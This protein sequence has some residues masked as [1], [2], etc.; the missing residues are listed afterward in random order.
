MSSNKYTGREEETKT[1]AP[2]NCNTNANSK[3]DILSLHRKH[4]DMA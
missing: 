3:Q 1:E 2:K 4:M